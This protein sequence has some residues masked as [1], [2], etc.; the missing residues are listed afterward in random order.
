[1]ILPNALVS[2]ALTAQAAETPPRNVLLEITD[3]PWI[4]KS[5]NMEIAQTVSVFATHTVLT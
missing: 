3:A 1:M 4:L 2:V 5:Q